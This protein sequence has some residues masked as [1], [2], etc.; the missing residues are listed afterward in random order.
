MHDLVAERLEITRLFTVYGKGLTE[1]QYQILAQYIEEDISLS[2]IAELSDVSRQAVHNLVQRTI[3]KLKR[4]EEIFGFID[5]L[6]GE[7]KKVEAAQKLVQSIK[8]EKQPAKAKESLEKLERKLA[9]IKY[10]D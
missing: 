2:E 8:A 3:T 5:I 1:K 7:Q 9:S 6:R 4:Y 10:L